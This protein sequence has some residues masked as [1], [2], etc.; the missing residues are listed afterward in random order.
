[1]VNLWVEN[2]VLHAIFVSKSCIQGRGAFDLWILIFGYFS[3]KSFDFFLP[4]KSFEFW[5]FRPTFKRTHDTRLFV[6]AKF[7][8]TKHSKLYILDPDSIHIRSWWE[9]ISTFL[10]FMSKGPGR[11]RDIPRIPIPKIGILVCK[12]S[13]WMIPCFIWIHRRNLLFSE[14]IAEYRDW[15]LEFILASFFDYIYNRSILLCGRFCL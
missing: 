13:F 12:F 7:S 8:I 14:L 11:D 5:F 6:L 9:C 3:I 2:R 1:L 15:N 4:S 10:E